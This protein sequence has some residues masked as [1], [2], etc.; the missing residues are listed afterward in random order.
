MTKLNL[1]AEIVKMGERPE[2][3][4]VEALDLK[5]RDLYSAMFLGPDAR[6]RAEE[7]ATAKFETARYRRSLV[8]E[9]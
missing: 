1:S 6:Q 2:T 8:G 7:Y 5:A 3:W 4:L 9:A